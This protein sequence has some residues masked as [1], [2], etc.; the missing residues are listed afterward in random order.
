MRPKGEG[1]GQGHAHRISTILSCLRFPGAGSEGMDLSS[2]GVCASPVL[3]REAMR[4][5]WETRS[6]MAAT[7]A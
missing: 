1:A 4:T 6:L 2:C 7:F 3:A 5:L